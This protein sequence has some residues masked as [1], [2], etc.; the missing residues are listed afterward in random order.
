[1]SL[2]Q[3]IFLKKNKR[4]SKK[5]KTPERKPL[6]PKG[7][8]VLEKESTEDFFV[9]RRDEGI[10]ELRI[11]EYADNTFDGSICIPNAPNPY[12][13]RC[14]S[15]PKPKYHFEA[16]SLRRSSLEKLLLYLTD[17]AHR[18]QIAMNHIDSILSV[19]PEDGRVREEAM[20]LQLYQGSIA[21]RM[22]DPKG[23]FDLSSQNLMS[24]DLE[25]ASKLEATMG[26]EPERVRKL[27][28][29]YPPQSVFQNA[30]AD[31]LRAILHLDEP[32]SSAKI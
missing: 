1:M 32:T 25:V 30:Y 24:V 13:W 19:R 2:F 23:I 22:T 11:R 7:F 3:K 17:T 20:F 21:A 28:N 26:L 9:I 15:H 4:S 18:L 16:N 27:L 31:S 5:T 14:G 8:R 12:T 6:L 10:I 29:T